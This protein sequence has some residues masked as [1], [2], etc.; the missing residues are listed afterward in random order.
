MGDRSRVLFSHLLSDLSDFLPSSVLALAARGELIE[1]WPD[2]SLKQQRAIS[3]LNSFYKKNI[4]SV[5]EEADLRCFEKFRA[6]NS[7]CGTFEMRLE[8][9]KDELLLGTLKKVL[10]DFLYPRGL[11]LVSGLNHVLSRL[12][13]GPGVALGA[14]GGDFYTKVF[15]SPLSSTSK[16]LYTA[17]RNY[18]ANSPLWGNAESFRQSHFG[19]EHIVAGNRISFVPKTRDISRLICSE[20]NL[21]MMFQLGL[22]DILTA[23]LKSYFGIDLRDQQFRNRE[24]ARIGSLHDSFVTIDLES[25]SDS[26]SLR[27]LREVL[28]SRFLG[29]LELFRSPVAALPPA[30][31]QGKAMELN[32]VSTMGNGFTFPLQTMLFSCA[33]LACYKVNYRKI[34]FPSRDSHGN[35]GVNGDDI[36]CEK[37]ISRDVCRILHLLGFV[38]NSKKTFLEGR[39][40]ESCGGDFF[41]G[42]QVRGVYVKTLQTPQSRYV[43]I[44]MLNN[45][46]AVTG[47]SLPQTVRYLLGSV[48]AQFVPSWENNDSGIRVPFDFVTDLRRDRDTQSI[49][50][51][52]SVAVPIKIRFKEDR[53]RL[54][55]KQKERLYNPDGLF[56]SL[57]QGC[58]ESESIGVRHDP[59]RYRTK[60][61]LCPNWDLVTA[62]CN[63][64]RWCLLYSLQG[65]PNA[66]CMHQ[67]PERGPGLQ[68][69]WQQW[70]TAVHLNIC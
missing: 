11:P 40:R 51:R 17:Y 24:L 67:T 52:K 14:L 64:C 3:L 19:S 66:V 28:P 45:W 22:G 42:H 65:I 12:R 34:V 59:V 39:F 6:V 21:N 2:I 63:T 43:A 33:V 13:T 55:R 27:M 10:D 26:M 56:I 49:L 20:P 4:D 62:N 1:S 54:P 35:F 61:S 29:Y 70:K 53:I 15:S 8:T 58:I 31:K 69:L 36:I 16:G 30:L 68:V 37:E 18:V 23:R 41:M 44:N 7:T 47:M 25:A 46:S 48:R 60:W 50:Y 57:L 38:V 5:S 9:T 32:M